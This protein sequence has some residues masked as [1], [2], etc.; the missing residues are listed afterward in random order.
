[1]RTHE[2]NGSRGRGGNFAAGVIE[3]L[4]Q[5]VRFAFRSLRKQPGLVLAALFTLGLGIGA[6]VAMFSVL[7]LALFQALPYP[8]AERLVLGRTQWPDGGISWTV[9]AP[10]YYDVRDQATSFE[11]LAALTP[12]ARDFTLT[13][14]GDAERISAAWISP[15]CF[16][17]LGVSPLL[18]R[19]F[20]PEESE[21]GGERVIM[22]SHELWQRRFSGDPGIIGSTV[23]I[24]GSPQT[25]VGVMPAEFEFVADVDA[26]APMVRG[27]MFAAA[28]QFHN[29][30]L[31]GRLRPGVSVTEAQSEVSVIMERL[32]EAYPSS[33]RG[34]GMAITPMQEAMVA[35]FRP[36]LLILMGAIALVLLIACANVASLL[37]ARG[38]GRRGE[39]ALRS[40]LGAR[41]PRLVG[42]LITESA[43][44]GLAAGLIG[45]LVAVSLQRTLVASTPLTRLGLEAAG[46]QP[47]VLLFAFGLALVTVLLFGLA[48]A[49]SAA[50][51]DL[52]EDL[53]SGSRSVAGGGRT[54]FRSGL[55]VAQVALSV[56]LLIGAGLLLRSF[57]QLRNSDPGFDSESLVTA[58]LGLLRA[59]YPE[60]IRRVQF[61]EELLERVSN[62]PGVLGASVIS[63]LPVRDPGNNIAVWDP[64]D[65]PA[66][67]SEW[68]LAYQR[69]VMPGYFETMGVPIRAGR[70]FDSSDGPGA[71]P[72]VI[73]NGTMAETLFPNQNPLG[74]QVANDEGDEV[75][76]YEV[77]GVVGDVQVSRLGGEIEMVMYFPYAQRPF[78][79]MRLAVR[80]AGSSL[81]IAGPLRSIVRQLDPD[82]P[83]ADLATMDEVLSRSVSFTRTVTTA[84]S[85]FAA[86][87]ILLAA[88]GLYGLLAFFVTQRSHEI[89]VRIALGATARSVLRLVMRRGAVLVGAGLLLGII[90]AFGATRLV[91]EQLYEVNATDPATFI[92]VSLFF[93][94]VALSACLIPAWRAC[95]VD[96]VE[97][98]RAE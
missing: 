19:E 89:G 27:V 8:E 92:S 98:F 11:S 93:V 6:N 7:N 62:V 88:L 75:G 5:D 29:W 61:Y 37:L 65:P 39:L 68:R 85:L 3:L 95:R 53:K 79:D 74:R 58:E 55:V 87:A 36:T 94:L 51:V 91:Q 46:L 18:G 84:L 30:L 4:F 76:Y 56:L 57:Y 48:P 44:L 60:R 71:P 69:T 73:I 64:A 33:N 66:D 13:G 54:R 15:G 42:Q 96:P 1:M 10:D 32:A 17:T 47:E 50:R 40:A 83:L 78:L 72:V 52:V 41:S 31:V 81:A 86:V 24:E 49:I 90:A 97:A 45:T 9:S 25:V 14:G 20:L 77:V 16:R 70:D 59:K 43:V 21:P 22:L 38:S 80:A 2:P 63:Q 26:W 28:R 82:V 23:S 67:A 12:F 34:K 35:N